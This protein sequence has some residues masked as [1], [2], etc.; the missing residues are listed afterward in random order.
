MTSLALIFSFAALGISET[1]YLIQKRRA[2]EKPICP[3]NEN[4]LAVLESR[5]RKI[6]FISNDILG[7][8][9]YVLCSFVAAFLVVGIEPLPFWNFV[10]KILI[11][12]GSVFSV[13]LTYLQFHVI[14]AWCF[15]CLM[16]AATIWLMGI[17]VLTARLY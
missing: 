13:F 1:S 10:I 6:F 11:L 12:L 8:L 9:F 5:Y 15:W 2:A 4:C 14:R 16:S 17:V 7:L 3:V